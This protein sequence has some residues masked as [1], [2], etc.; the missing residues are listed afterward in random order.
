MFGEDISNYIHK[1]KPC[2][3]FIYPDKS[4]M[5]YKKLSIVHRNR[6]IIENTDFIIAYNR[7]QGKAYD[8]CKVAKGKG[9]KV[10]EVGQVAMSE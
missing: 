7:Y 10:I 8:F 5:G 9:V 1:G 4:A 6:Y 3:D 2:D